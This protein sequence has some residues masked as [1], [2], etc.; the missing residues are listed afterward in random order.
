MNYSIGPNNTSYTFRCTAVVGSTPLPIA[1]KNAGA[2]R[3]KLIGVIRDFMTT[4]GGATPSS[5]LETYLT[6][7]A[8]LLSRLV[9]GDGLITLLKEVADKSGAFVDGGGTAV[10]GLTDGR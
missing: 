10:G 1:L 9:A 6:A 7:V 3:T 2:D 5:D 4:S 8:A